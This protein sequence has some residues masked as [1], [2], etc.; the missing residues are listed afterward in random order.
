VILSG[1]TSSPP[2]PPYTLTRGGPCA[3]LH[4]RGF[5]R[6]AHSQTQVTSPPHPPYTLTHGGLRPAP[7]AW[8]RS[9]RS[10]TSDCRRADL[11]VCQIRRA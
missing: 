3:P 8:V 5:V 6:F 7:F 4:S 2:H 9:L 10:L 1:G 11:Q